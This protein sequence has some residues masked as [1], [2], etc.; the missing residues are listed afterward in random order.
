MSDERPVA[1]KK[2]KRNSDSADSRKVCIVHDSTICSSSV[3]VG[4]LCINSFEKI[5]EAVAIRQIQLNEGCQKNEIC[6]SVPEEF[7]SALHGVHWKCC[8]NFTNV[9][10]RGLVANFTFRGQ[11]SYLVR[12]T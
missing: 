7:D 12:G 2:L 6:A 1:L 8:R 3:P 4:N 5:R 11:I 9:R 10:I